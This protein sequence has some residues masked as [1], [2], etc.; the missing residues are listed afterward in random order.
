MVTLVPNH[1]VAPGLTSKPIYGTELDNLHRIAEQSDIVDKPAADY[2]FLREQYPVSRLPLDFEAQIEKFYTLGKPDAPPDD[3]LWVFTFGTWDVWNL[4]A[5]PIQSSEPIIDA[6]TEHIFKQIERLYIDALNTKSIA[7]S[8][9]WGRKSKREI[10]ELTDTEPL[11]DSEPPENMDLR[12]LES[13]RIL[14]PELFDLSLAPGWHSRPE[15]PIPYSDAQQVRNSAILTKRWNERMAK[16]MEEW[17]KKGS[18]RPAKLEDEPELQPIDLP[19]A[20]LVLNRVSPIKKEEKKEG[21]EDQKEGEEEHKDEDKKD[22][23]DGNNVYAPWPRRL[24]HHSMMASRVVDAMTE[25]EMQR[26]GAKDSNGRG[27]ADEDDQMRFEDV[28]KSCIENRVKVPKIPREPPAEECEVLDDHLFLDGF[29]VAQRATKNLAKR[30]ASG[31][32]EHLLY[33]RISHDRIHT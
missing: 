7:F 25:E 17:T 33:R 19:Q 11:T 30:A 22:K 8:D 10:E 14:I 27:D 26:A 3:T 21:E 16:L 23:R 9:F 31:V 15:P 29:T 2:F 4:A 13:F 24:A 28:W 5:M 20:D 6:L 1:G 12:K 18:A 32:S